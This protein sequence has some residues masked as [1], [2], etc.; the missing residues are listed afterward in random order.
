M[1]RKLINYFNEEDINGSTLPLAD[2]RIVSVAPVDTTNPTDGSTGQPFYSVTLVKDTTR[3]P[4]ILTD[5]LRQVKVAVFQR[6]YPELFRVIEEKMEEMN[7]QRV[8]GVEPKNLFADDIFQLKHGQVFS[9]I[10]YFARDPESEVGKDGKHDYFRFRSD[11]GDH[12][13]GDKIPATKHTITLM[14]DESPIPILTRLM[15]RLEWAVEPT[16][17]G[18]P[19]IDSAITA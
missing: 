14:P 3:N 2:F 8:S 5:R 11:V 12:K 4:H 9:K 17:A 19:E 18:A 10:P 15:N 1:A 7:K 6:N 16:D 13:R